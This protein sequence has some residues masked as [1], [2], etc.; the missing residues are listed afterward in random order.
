MEDGMNI[1][2]ADDELNIRNILTEELQHIGHLV[3]PCADGTEALAA[4]QDR[5]FDVLLLDLDMPGIGGLSLIEEARKLNTP[6]DIVILT[7]KGTLEAAQQAIHYAVSEF[8][9]KPYMITDLE[10][11]LSAIETKRS[12]KSGSAAKLSE[13]KRSVET[14]VPVK[15]IGNSEAMQN[16]HR[17]IER[18]APTDSTVVI[19]GETGTGKELVAR[20]I[21]QLSKRKDK[22]FVAVNCGALP[23]NLIESELFGHRRG[24]FTGADTNRTGL[25][26]V[27]DGG[28]L[29]LDEIGE[30]PKGVQAKLLRFLENGEVRK[31][32]GNTPVLCDVRV[33]CATLRHLESMV[34]DGSFREDLWFRINTFEIHIPALKERKED[35]P[36]LILYLAKRCRSK[37]TA[38]NAADIFSPETYCALLQY[39]Y[40]GNVRQLANTI[41]HALVLSDRLPVPLDALPPQIKN[42][43]L[44]AAES[45]KRT[46]GTL[47]VKRPDTK[48]KE[49][50]DVIVTDSIVLKKNTGDIRE[51]NGG[52]AVNVLPPTVSFVSLPSIVSLRD[53]EMQA[54]ETALQR[55]GGNKAKAAEELGIS[56][57]T[58][59]NKLNQTER[60]SA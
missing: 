18:I 16:V 42:E 11:I 45:A 5:D 28:T 59:Y 44:S 29:F 12:T 39:D 34:Q 43:Y 57:K 41:E 1:L 35:L 47:P 6:A 24:S 52:E 53:L 20:S 9:T 48:T 3:T 22:P 14:K 27:A 8:L 58:L 21:H 51:T 31:I 46:F 49:R 23:E 10:R 33:V 2:L 50:P 30:L 37:L 38:K 15:I 26:E 36:D 32:G 56:L 25:F 55:Q 60:K 7:G 19:L 54:I 40:P 17:L 13:A 4:L